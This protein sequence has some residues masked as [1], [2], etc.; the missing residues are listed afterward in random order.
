M[1]TQRPNFKVADGV[2]TASFHAGRI[3]AVKKDA[4]SIQYDDGDFERN[5]SVERIRPLVRIDES[6]IRSVS[7]RVP[8]EKREA[9][10]EKL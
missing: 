4:Y 10:C 3:A 9:V 8:L 7:G 2:V 6:R 5:V 1:P